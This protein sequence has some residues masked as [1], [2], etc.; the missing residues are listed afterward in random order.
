ML[1]VGYVFE[2]P[3]FVR[4]ESQL[5]MAN[6]LQKKIRLHGGSFSQSY[7]SA[8]HKGNF[9]IYQMEMRFYAYD[10]IFIGIL[11]FFYVYLELA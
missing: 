7:S 8:R 11:I 4:D 6:L 9:R 5:I 1:I 2:I 3:Y 10:I